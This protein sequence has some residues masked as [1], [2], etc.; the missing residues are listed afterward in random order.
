[1]NHH[2]LKQTDWT[3]KTLSE[4]TGVSI[5][6]LHFYEKK[7]LIN[8]SRTAGN[9]RRYR[10]DVARRLA[11]I[12]AAQQ[13]GISLSDIKQTLQQLPDDR[14]PT[15]EDWQAIS[16]TWTELLNQRIEQLV[17]LRDKVSSCVKCGCLSLEK[18]QIY[19]HSDK[20]SQTLKQPSTFIANQ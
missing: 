19:N 13:V 1:M 12:Q 3:P 16:A 7:G 20:A 2:Q 15:A 14:T 9:Q 4:R 17:N 10:R 18:C 8:A 6:T 5:P 11:F